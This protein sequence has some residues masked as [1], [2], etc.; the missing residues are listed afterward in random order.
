MRTGKNE[1]QILNCYLE[2]G[3]K[4]FQ[5]DRASRL[6]DIIKDIIKQ[7]VNS[8]IVLCGDF[9]NHIHHMYSQLHFL[10]LTKQWTQALSP[11]NWVD[12]WTRSSLATIPIHWSMMALIV[13]SDYRCLK[14][15]LKIK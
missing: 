15:S 6:T 1:V 5:K 4:Q 11:I 12:T 2:P 8:A 7:N 3:E 9:N 13:E 14:V 10:C